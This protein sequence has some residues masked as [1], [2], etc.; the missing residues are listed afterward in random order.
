M[1]TQKH[2]SLNTRL[3]AT[4][5]ATVIALVV[6]FVGVLYTERALLFKDRQEKVRSLVEVAHGVITQHEKAVSE[7]KMTLEAAQA[8]ALAVIRN[9]RYDTSEYFW[10]NDMAPKVLMHP[11][12]PELDG[13]DM[14]ALKDPK[15]KLLFNEFVA[16]VNKDGKGF[17]DYYWPKPGAD[18][19]VAKISYVMGFKPWGWIVGSGIYLDDVNKI[20]REEAI[21]FL[22]WGLIV[23]AIVAVPLILMRRN[24]LRLLGGDPSRAVAVAR[25]IAAGD[26][27]TDI[28]C[29]PGD[30][31]SLLAGMKDMQGNLRSMIHEVIEGAENLGRASQDMMQSAE[32][33]SH[34]AGKQ[35][36]AASSISVSV[37]EMT[38]SMNLVEDSAREAFTLSQQAGVL[39][40]N[41]TT[42][43]QDATAEMRRLSDAVNTSSTAIQELGRQSEQITSIVNTI[44]EIADQTNLLALNAAIEAA[45]AGEQGRGFAVVADEVRKLAERTALST[46]DIATTVSSIQAGTHGAV[47][48]MES[49]VSQAAKGV[50]LAEQGGESI[51]QIRDSSKRVLAVVNDITGALQEQSSA[52]KQ[53][54]TSVGEIAAMSDQTST[55]LNQT[56]DAARRLLELSSSLQQS[57]KRFKGV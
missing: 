13:K 9:M 29:H 5:L 41:G 51:H 50:S 15:G 36:E 53:I 33:V 8:G 6:L 25:R 35:S 7:G 47:A 17:V 31:E 11:I 24:L 37:M 19:P 20:F 23:A 30:K 52:T 26:I 32:N 12:K 49:G 10:V 42:V 16:V 54:S 1:H 18:E 39:A 34:H 44:K 21:K 4:I 28:E 56:V 55:S 48:S 57:V 22:L 40:D 43:I 27:G 3:I 46:A 2:I 38:I 14:S 45:R